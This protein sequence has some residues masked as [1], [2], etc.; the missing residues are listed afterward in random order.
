MGQLRE[1]AMPL[2]VSCPSCHTKFHVADEY[3]EKRGKCPRCGSEI[4]IAAPL[5]SATFN[6]SPHPE[7]RSM[8]DHR[9]LA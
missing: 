4:L 8:G 7:C 9:I 6:L 2:I 1:A 3:A 5:A